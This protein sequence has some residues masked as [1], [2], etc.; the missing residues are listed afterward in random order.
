M[1]FE[2]FPKISRLNREVIVT[3]KIDG[4]NAQI[5]IRPYDDRFEPGIDVQLDGV[6]MRCG[7]RNRFLSID[8]DHFGFWAWM[9]KNAYDLQRLGPGQH[10]GEWWGAGV[11]R[12]NYG[13]TVKR[14]S[15]FNTHRWED[16]GVRPS[17]CHV[18]PVLARGT[19]FGPVAEALE[20]LRT[21]GSIAAPGFMRPEGIVAFHTHNSAMFKV[22]LE[23]DEVPKSQ[24]AA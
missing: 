21:E 12:R 22:T 19:G 14:F 5:H 11:G 17:C 15:L 20:I 23:K 8:N 7:S 18:V 1:N 16:E 9:Y 4:T 13:L 2:E 24:V 3:E 6:F 10:F